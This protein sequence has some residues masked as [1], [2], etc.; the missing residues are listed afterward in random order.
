MC[1]IFPIILS[2]TIGVAELMQLIKNNL[3]IPF[4]EEEL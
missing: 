2:F 3:I 1:I 4:K